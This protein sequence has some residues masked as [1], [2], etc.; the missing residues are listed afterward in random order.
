MKFFA[1]LKSA[2]FAAKVS[3]AA[4]F[5]IEAALKSGNEAALKEF[6][7]AQVAAAKPDDKLTAQVATLEAALQ[8]ATAENAT[9]TGTLNA[10]G[11]KFPAHA[12]GTTS[13]E[14]IAANKTAMEAHIKIRAQGILAQTGVP[15]VAD[16]PTTPAAVKPQGRD[17]VVAS[18]EAGLLK[19]NARKTG[20]S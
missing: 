7:A 15:A 6:I 13:E 5:D 18:F 14:Q 10:V 9:L 16:V 8:S 12:E 17:L 20:A 4:G 3:A 1:A 2:E 19:L 11:V